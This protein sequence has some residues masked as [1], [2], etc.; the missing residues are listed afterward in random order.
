VWLFKAA[1]IS[2]SLLAKGT[3]LPYATALRMGKFGYQ[4]SPQRQ[5]GIQ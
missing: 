3:L 1:S 4:N 5:L 2:Y